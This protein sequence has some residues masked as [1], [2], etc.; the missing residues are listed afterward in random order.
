MHRAPFYEIFIPT[1]FNYRFAGLVGCLRAKCGCSP[2]EYCVSSYYKHSVYINSRTSNWVA[3]L[4]ILL[5]LD[6]LT[7]HFLNAIR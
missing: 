6:I 3:A 2:I 4:L 5:R 1:P 7:V